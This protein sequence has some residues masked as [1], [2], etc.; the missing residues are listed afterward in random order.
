MPVAF[1]LAVLRHVALAV[2]VGGHVA[3]VDGEVAAVG[4]QLRFQP[5]DH[6]VDAALDRLAIVAQLFG[7][8]VGGPL[9]RRFALAVEDPL[10]LPVLGDQGDDFGPRRQRVEALGESQADHGADRVAGSARPAGSF[11]FLDQPPDLGRIEELFERD[12]CR[13]PCY[14]G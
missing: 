12:G 4:R 3:R 5:Y 10:Q 2:R 14:F 11:E 9:A 7:E 1:G 6:R 13:A 8:A